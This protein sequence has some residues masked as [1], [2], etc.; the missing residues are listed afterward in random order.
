MRMCHSMGDCIFSW[1]KETIPVPAT[2]ERLVRPRDQ[3]MA[4]GGAGAQV[5]G[6]KDVQ[7][8]MLL[9]I[10]RYVIDNTFGCRTWMLKD[11]ETSKMTLKL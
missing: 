2:G 7:V 11:C 4:L 3:W 9:L 6:D 5:T 8:G 1:Q 10:G